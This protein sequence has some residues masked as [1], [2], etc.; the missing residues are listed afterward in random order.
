MKEAQDFPEDFD[1]IVAGA[2][3]WD[4]TDLTTWSYW[5]SANA[6]FD[7]SSDAFIPKAL[8]TV[9]NDEVIRQC[10]GFDGAVD[11]IIEDTDLCVPKLETLL[12]GPNPTNTSACLNQGQYSRAVKTFE[13][14][15]NGPGDLMYP[16]L[17]PS[18]HEAASSVMFGGKPF[19]Y[20]ADWF[21]Y[22]VYNDEDLD[23][24]N[25]GQKDFA[26]A[27]ALDPYNIS[28][29]KGDLSAFASRGGKILTYHGLSDQL[30][31]SEN[32]ARYYSHL[33]QTMGLRPE[34]LDEFYRFF[35]VGGM[36]H[37]GSGAG[38]NDLGQTYVG[39][40]AGVSNRENNVLEAI[41]G[42][43]EQGIAP[44]FIEGIKWKGDRPVGGEAFRRRHCKFPGRNVY[45]GSGD[46]GDEDGWECV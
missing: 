29:W 20:S 33:S 10:D 39:R 37:C 14:F 45:K 35:R 36:Q 34:Q 1:G 18:A 38:A 21:K 3:A 40:P 44:E 13:P 9:I 25:L 41:V 43:V 26:Y 16:R 15:Y 31:S 27:R 12:C 4:F 8:W 11:G 19:Q 28:T 24:T 6:G 7:N 22:V 5:L 2:P 32:S 46:G 30:I 42:W 17:Q 23:V